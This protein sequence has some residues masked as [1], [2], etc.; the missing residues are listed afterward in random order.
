MADPKVIPFAPP[1]NL[2][3]K[4][5]ISAD[6]IHVSFRGKKVLNGLSFGVPSSGITAL[7]GPNGGGKSL[8][9]RL[10]AGLLDEFEGE[11]T[12]GAQLQQRR[13]IVFQSPVLLRRSVKAN[14]S[15]AL[16]VYGTPRNERPDRL[17]ALLDAA[18]LGQKAETPARALSGG[19]KQLLA[20]VRAIA[21]EPNLLLLDEPTASL[22]P[23]S[24]AAIETLTR[25]VADRGA[26]IILVS[27]DWA[28]AQRLADDVLF[29][30]NGRITEHSSAH[31][32]FAKPTSPEAQ[33]YL[34][35]R[36]LL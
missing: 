4:T 34:E 25:E 7:L 3:A 18:G 16:K 8:T 12:M 2:G 6:D 27:H 19:E 30:H 11:L 31:K 9:L 13:M 32:F 5:L 36:L 15:H 35:G 22:D 10:L 26:K 24:V 23:H 14:L 33:Q 17:A 28:Q 21:A 20:M 1:S 29:L